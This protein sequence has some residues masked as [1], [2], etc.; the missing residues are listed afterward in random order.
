MVPFTTRNMIPEKIRKRKYRNP[1]PE[2]NE[3]LCDAFAVW[4][5]EVLLCMVRRLFLHSTVFRT[6][7]DHHGGRQTFVNWALMCKELVLDL[8]ILTL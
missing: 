6:Q 7:F 8:K 4:F 1:K 3:T 2:G 5:P